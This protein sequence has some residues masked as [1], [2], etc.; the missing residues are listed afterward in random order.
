VDVLDLVEDELGLLTEE[1]LLLEPPLKLLLLEELDER[2]DEELV[3]AN[4]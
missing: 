3:A 4:A 2:E 1:L